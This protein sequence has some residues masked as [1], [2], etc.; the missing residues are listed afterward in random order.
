LAFKVRWH[1]G[2][3]DDLQK[4]DKE[5]A[6]KIIERV[7]THL[8]VDPVK[9]GKALTGQF[10]GLY[11][12]QYGAYRVVYA[13]DLAEEKILILKVRHRKNAYQD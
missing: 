7:N 5:T 6:R 2:I 3:S 8:I 13:V 9:L 4:L 11:R 12:Y 10:Q 1:E